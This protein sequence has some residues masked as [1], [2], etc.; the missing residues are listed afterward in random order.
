MKRT[1]SV[2]SLAF[3]LNSDLVLKTELLALPFSPFGSEHA[4]F[5]KPIPRLG[6]R[7]SYPSMS[8]RIIQPYELNRRI[9]ALDTD[10]AFANNV[11]S[12]FALLARSKI[13]HQ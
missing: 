3:V 12:S 6:K 7:E 13:V 11:L 8:F 9:D 1:E 10:A 5:F 4:P 2:A